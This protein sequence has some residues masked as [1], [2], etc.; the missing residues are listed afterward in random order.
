LVE[1]SGF[2][3]YRILHVQTWSIRLLMSYLHAFK[4]FLLPNKSMNL[5]K[6]NK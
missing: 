6:S 2:S 5:I 1:S 3:T 4:V